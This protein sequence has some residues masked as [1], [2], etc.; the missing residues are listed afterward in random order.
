MRDWLRD[1][2]VAAIEDVVWADLGEVAR[3]AGATDA[4]ALGNALADERSAG[5]T[6]PP[7][8]PGI[9]V[10]AIADTGGE[11][12]QV[13]VGQASR[14]RSRLADHLRKLRGRLS[15][16]G[17]VPF[18]HAHDAYYRAVAIPGDFSDVAEK[19][20]IKH[21][22]SKKLAAWNNSGFGRHDPGGNRSESVNLAGFD[23][24][25]PINLDFGVE[26]DD[27]GPLEGREWY[28]SLRLAFPF[29]M[30]EPRVP[31]TAQGRP[32]EQSFEEARFRCPPGPTTPRELLAVT[33]AS[34]PTGWT[35]VAYRDL[36][37]ISRNRLRTDSPHV[38]D[39]WTSD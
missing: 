7:D 9:Y 17:G 4:R 14:L 11:P 28:E 35:I 32:W 24:S 21:Y 18:L 16:Q 39:W 10:L 8:T 15:G 36:V 27:I 5:T 13:Y 33:A 12:T 22:K 25:Y 6:A 26:W 31:G 37:A 23:A 1:G 3:A 2:I 20:L 29:H 34:L 38:L 30:R 19:A